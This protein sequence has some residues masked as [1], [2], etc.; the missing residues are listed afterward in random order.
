[1][2]RQA[3]HAVQLAALRLSWRGR[4]HGKRVDRPG[5]LLRQSL[6][7]DPVPLDAALSSEGRRYHINPEM[8]LTFRPVTGVAGME[9]RL[10]LDP[11]ALG[12]QRLL[13]LVLNARF[14]RHDAAILP[15]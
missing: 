7:H 13:Q 3:Q 10:V 6:V 5:K 11:Q 2:R 4:M 8:G 1:M 15:E 12:P 14:D 9:V